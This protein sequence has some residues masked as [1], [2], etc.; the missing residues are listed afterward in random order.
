MAIRELHN[1][2]IVQEFNQSRASGSKEKY[3]ICMKGS[4]QTS[5]SKQRKEVAK[6]KRAE[7][8]ECKVKHQ[9]PPC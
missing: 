8:Q 4:A 2:F 5:S 1:T 9:K 6:K 7:K 3:R